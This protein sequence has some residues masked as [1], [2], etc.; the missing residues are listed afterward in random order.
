[1]AGI[2]DKNANPLNWLTTGQPFWTMSPSYFSNY[3]VS[4]AMWNVVSD[5]VLYN[6]GWTD[7]YW[8]GVRPV[9]NLKKDT[10]ISEGNGT[11]ANPY[12]IAS[13]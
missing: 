11:K 8:L 9:I 4:S 10:L 2:S 1:M 6:D 13:N 12:V 7:C 5:G 3:R